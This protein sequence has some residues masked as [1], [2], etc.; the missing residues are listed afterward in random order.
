[1]VKRKVK[2]V[3]KCITMS[4]KSEYMLKALMKDMQMTASAVI[5]RFIAREYRK[6]YGTLEIAK[7][8]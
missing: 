5:R 4:K 3:V 2:C 8:K 6:K 1:M 7:E